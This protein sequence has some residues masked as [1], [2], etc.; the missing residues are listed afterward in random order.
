MDPT[1]TTQDRRCPATHP[2]TALVQLA[3]STRRAWSKQQRIGVGEKGRKRGVGRDGSCRFL[4][5]CRSIFLHVYYPNQPTNQPTKL[6]VGLVAPHPS[7]SVYHIPVPLPRNAKPCNHAKETRES[8]EQA[9]K[10][11][12]RPCTPEREVPRRP[13]CM[14]MCVREEGRTRGRAQAI[15]RKTRA[16]LG[17]P[18]EQGRRGKERAGGKKFIS[19]F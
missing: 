19:L 14:Y 18:L 6:C 9:S 5:Y 10:Q 13:K 17:T 11:R 1:T 7:T 4:Y 12:R 15:N 8:R 2:P 3:F 16:T